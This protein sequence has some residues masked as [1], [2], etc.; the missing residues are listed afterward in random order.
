MKNIQN[1]DDAY[2]K[3]Y[4]DFC[5]QTPS[6]AVLT[7]A[8]YSFSLWANNSQRF[9]FCDSNQCADMRTFFQNYRTH[10]VMADIENQLLI[11]TCDVL[12]NLY[13]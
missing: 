4:I 13:K 7:L 5:C 2:K 3:N 1:V 6:A 11:L 12:E 8:N 9:Q 10:F